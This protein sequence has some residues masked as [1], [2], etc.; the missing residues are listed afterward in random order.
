M[1][2]VWVR[3]QSQFGFSVL[4]VLKSLSRHHQILFL[5]RFY[6]ILDFPIGT[7]CRKVWTKR[8]KDKFVIHR[9]FLSFPA[10]IR[11]KMQYTWTNEAYAK[12]AFH[13]AKYLSHSLTGLLLGHVSNS[14]IQIVDAMP[15]FHSQ[16]L[17]PTMEMALLSVC[18]LF[19]G[20]N[21]RLSRIE[22]HNWI[23]R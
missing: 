1:E 19:Y 11:S 8:E 23:F 12:V 16:I 6:S 22:A 9:S 21:S 18:Y 13:S 4:C 17:A 3:S 2:I 15:L 14:E 5:T 10:L 7:S 20:E